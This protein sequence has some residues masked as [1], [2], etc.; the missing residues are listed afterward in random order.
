MTDKEKREIAKK[1]F[2]VGQWTPL[3]QTLIELGI[4][5]C[6]EFYDAKIDAQA[7]TME[8]LYEMFKEHSQFPRLIGYFK[9][10]FLDAAIKEAIEK[11]KAKTLG[12][13]SDKLKKNDLVRVKDVLDILEEI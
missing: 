9:A 6:C 12:G 3:E 2:T 10:G 5:R 4:E 7:K 1:R 13:E 11:I 8:E